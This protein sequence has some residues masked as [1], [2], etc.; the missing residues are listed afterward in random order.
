MRAR[1][2]LDVDEES[3]PVAQMIDYVKPRLLMEDAPVSLR[4]MLHNTRCCTSPSRWA[5][6]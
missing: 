5:I 6:S 3:V 4:R 1:P 2:V